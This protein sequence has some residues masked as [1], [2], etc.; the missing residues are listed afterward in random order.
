MPPISQQKIQKIKEQILFHLYNIF[1]KQIFTS[2]IARELARDEEFIKKIL[3]QLYKNHL[4]IKID[5]NPKGVKYTRRC[6]WR[7]S[8]KAQQAYSKHQISAQPQLKL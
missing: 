8:N 2:D 1:P 7:L 4:I 5:K 6:R 3:T